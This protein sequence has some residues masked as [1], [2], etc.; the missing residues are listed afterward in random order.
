VSADPRSE[1]IGAGPFA[2]AVPH[3]VLCAVDDAMAEAWQQAAADHD[4]IAVHHGSV[5]D[6]GAQ[7][8]VSPAN[9]YGWM[10]GGID[11][12]YAELFPDVESAV[13]SA[14]LAL[15]GGELPVGEAMIVPTGLEE[16][17]WLISAPTMKEPA[18]TLPPDTVNPYLAALAVFRL[19]REGTLDDGTHVRDAVATIA[20][21]GLG[22]GVGG[23]S[24]AA[25]ARQVVAAWDSIFP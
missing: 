14:V 17:R 10:R 1:A 7:A 11:A 2:V 20:M 21:P 16:P 4:A 19:W 22:T 18:T 3:L 23:V 5:I 12:F 6:V 15:H 9:S 24:P 8:V 25:C 13:R